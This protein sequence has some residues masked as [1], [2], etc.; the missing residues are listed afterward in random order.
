MACRPD[1]LGRRQ[2]GT[3]VRTERRATSHAHHRAPQGRVE[4]AQAVAT[5]GHVLDVR[6]A[7][8]AA[9]DERRQGRE[10]VAAA[11]DRHSAR[12]SA[13]SMASDAPSA[14][15]GAVAWAASPMSTTRPF[16]QVGGETSSNGENHSSSD[17]RRRA[18]N[19]GTGSG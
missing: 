17:D 19:E 18:S 1:G 15:F 7:R 6:D 10:E 14:M 11:D 4:V 9:L 2:Q 13:S 12:T 8:R 5:A 3:V 16:D